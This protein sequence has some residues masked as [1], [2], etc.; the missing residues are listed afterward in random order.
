M[1]IKFTV[2]NSE[3]TY[4]GVSKNR[5]MCEDREEKDKLYFILME[6]IIILMA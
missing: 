2:F 1:S 3:G 6:I 4:F 5:T